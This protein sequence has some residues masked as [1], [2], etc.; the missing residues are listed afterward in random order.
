M[1]SAGGTSWEA[2]RGDDAPR[3]S[4]IRGFRLRVSGQL[5]DL[6]RNAQRVLAYLALH[7]VAVPRDHLA[8][9]LWMDMSEERAGANLRTA[10]WRINRLG[11][12]LVSTRAGDIGLAPG[13]SV[14]VRIAANRAARL[15]S[16][17][18]PIPPLD[19]T[20]EDFDA[21]VLP[22]WY[23]DWV[24]VDQERFRQIRLHALEEICA[25][26]TL[27]RRFADAIQAGIAAVTCEPLRET[28]QTALIKAFLAEGNVFEA[29]RQ[30]ESYRA[31]LLE[32][33]GIEPGPA[34]GSLIPRGHEAKPP[35][36][37]FSTIGTATAS[38][39][40]AVVR[41][42]PTSAVDAARDG[43]ETAGTEDR[44][45]PVDPIGATRR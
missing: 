38:S 35:L 14:D 31:L 9:C 20:V 42:T 23:E 25:R 3:L 33:L 30:Y 1:G 36:A 18:T 26:L 45:R 19:L 15:T 5:I 37:N 28:A 17:S 8:Q 24:L 41:R 10:L 16:S 22:G 6:P 29:V 12:A 44:A 7:D 13:V 39:G 43:A 40:L 34:I 32:A 11:L 21:D 2:G 27:E 4:L